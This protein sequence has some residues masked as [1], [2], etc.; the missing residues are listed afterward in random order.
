MLFAIFTVSATMLGKGRTRSLGRS[1]EYTIARYHY[2][3][4]WPLVRPAI[5]CCQAT[6]G[7][8]PTS[9][10]WKDT[11][12]SAIPPI[13]VMGSQLSLQRLQDCG[14][15]QN[16]REALWALSGGRVWGLA[17]RVETPHMRGRLLVTG[18]TH[19]PIETRSY[20]RKTLRSQSWDF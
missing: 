1:S 8:F 20:R 17:W 13:R 9:K 12:A 7:P 16:E 3:F 15:T 2:M 18:P 10:I 5:T 6:C 14:E 4:S 19:G 11:E